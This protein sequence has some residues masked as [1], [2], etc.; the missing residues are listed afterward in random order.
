MTY[1]VVMFDRDGGELDPEGPFDCLYEAVC[2]GECML[3]C[4]WV[5]YEIQEG[6]DDA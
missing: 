4:Q 6:D 1:W 3:D 2:C 5:T